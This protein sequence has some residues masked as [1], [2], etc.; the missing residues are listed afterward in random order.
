MIVATFCVKL[1]GKQQY[2]VPLAVTIPL[3]AIILLTVF[4]L[5]ESPRWLL[6]RNQDEKA[7][8]SLQRIRPSL[9]HTT[10]IKDEL[11]EMKAAITEEK[12]QATGSALRDIIRNPVD[13]RRTT[14]SVVVELTERATGA[15]WQN[16]TSR[17]WNTYL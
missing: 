7:L 16:S 6:L 10:C 1:G 13:R 8:R 15:T 2:Q 11:L 17:H 3:P 9:Q 5:P 4:L 12:R 14:L